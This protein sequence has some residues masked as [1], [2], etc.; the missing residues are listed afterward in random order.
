MVGPVLNTP[1]R[2][3]GIDMEDVQGLVRFAHGHLGESA[4]L[5]LAVKNPDTARQWLAQAQVSTAV[6]QSTRPESAL[7]VAFTAPGLEALGLAQSTLKSF[8]EEFTTGMNGDENL[9]RRLGDTGSNHPRHWRWGGATMNTPHVLLMIYTLPGE[10]QGYLRETLTRDFTAAFEVQHTLNSASTGPEEPFGFAD[11]ISQ[12]VIDWQQPVRDG[13]C[14]RD[15]YDNRLAPGEVLLGYPNEY[16]LYTD[17]PLLHSAEVPASLVLPTAI[18]HPRLRDLGRNGSYLVLRQL[19]QDVPAFWRFVDEQSDSDAARREQLAAAMVGRQ[20]DGTPLV[21]LSSEHTAGMAAD[22]RFTFDND[23]LGLQCPVG[24][25]I[26]RANPRTGDFPP[27]V[28]NALKRLLCKVGFDRKHAA[29]DLVAASRFHRILRR[30]RVYGSPLTPQQALRKIPLKKAQEERG[31]IFVCLSA[32]IE[33]QFE[34]VQNA[35]IANSKFAG[36]PTESDPLLGNREPLASGMATNSF[37][38]P[39]AGEPAQCTRGLPQ[40][41]TVRGGAY[42]FMPGLRALK[43]ILRQK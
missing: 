20:R 2:Q 1:A 18:D 15:A 29:Q 21:P 30:G 17:R 42:F 8:S 11:G 12:P 34:F 10:L 16:G 9:S 31:L 5:L 25:H 38:Q 26:R 39:R 3:L 35:W 24:A 14:E 19:A 4:F 7:Q 43:F 37:S 40:F 28:D 36:L 27:G 32:N 6:T 33:R 41:V 23:P 13:P 22:N